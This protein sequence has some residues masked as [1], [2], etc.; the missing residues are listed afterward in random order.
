MTTS[1]ST[2]FLDAARELAPGFAARAGHW[3][4]TR[5]YCW[6]NVRALADAGLT[7]MT[8]PTAWGGAGASYLERRGKSARFTRLLGGV[9]TLLHG[10]SLTLLGVAGLVDDNNSDVAGYIFLPA[11]VLGMVV[12]AIHFF[13]DT[14]PERL[15]HGLPERAQTAASLRLAPH[16][17]LGIFGELRLFLS[18]RGRF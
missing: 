18:M 4:Q 2:R 11:G 3:D 13:G 5:S 6:D 10:A 16:A 12:G 17:S 15:L 14:H 9:L 7:G 1:E 8:I